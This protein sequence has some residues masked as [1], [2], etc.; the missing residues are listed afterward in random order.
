M[1]AIVLSGGGAKGSYQIGVWKALR[2]LH[3]KYDLITG[4]SSG[5]LN[6]ALMVQ[7]DYRKAIS[8]W[9]KINFKMLFGE[10]ITDINNKLDI[11]K[12][13]GKEFIRNGGMD[14]TELENIINKT[15]NKRKFFKS[16]INF[17]LV[18][19]N[20]TDKKAEEIQ[21]KEIKEEHLEDYLMASATCYPAFKQK[22]IK[23]EKYIDGGYYDN[24]PINLAIKMGA[25]E[26]IAVDLRAPGFKRTIK[27]KAKITMIKPN[28]KLT[29]FLNFNEEGIKRN[30]KFGYNDTMK[31]FNK[32]EGNKYTFKKGHLK[33]NQ[34]LYGE[35]YKHIVK[36]ILNSQKLIK[37]IKEFSDL[38][39]NKN[40]I[41]KEVFIKVMEYTAKTFNLDETKIYSHTSFNNAIK[42][43]LK[44]RL[45]QETNHKKITEI[46]IYKEI[47]KENYKELRKLAITNPTDLIKAIYLYTICEA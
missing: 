6:G 45:K 31:I 10:D 24:L 30:I 46:D 9:K 11:Y 28:N 38:A 29:N 34:E 21:K 2:K 33:K 5:A 44:K 1:K 36:K 41:K 16:K 25:T 22:E 14:V 39:P 12:I 26:I 37:Q 13:Y 8:L 7:N 17:G 19:Y 18:T 32:L 40:E 3:I 4:T 42:K 27:K 15:I 43:E 47:L 20:I 23:G 35:T